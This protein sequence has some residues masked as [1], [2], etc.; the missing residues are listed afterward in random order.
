MPTP[1]KGLGK[2]ERFALSSLAALEQ[3]VVTANDV[4]RVAGLGRPGA[5]Q[6]LSR[7]AR[8]GWLIR[9]RRGAYSLVA[10]S[11]RSG[12]TSSE[13]PMA[14]AMTLF[15]PCYISGWTTAQHWG[16]TE[17]IYNSI[18]VCSAAPQRAAEQVAGGIMFRVRRVPARAI[19]GTTRIWSG[20]TAVEVAN[21]HRTLID[22][23][24]TP[25]LGGGGRQML[26]IAQAYWQ[27]GDA[28]PDTLLEYAERL[29]RGVIF[30][31][32]GLTAEL[33]GDVPSAWF[34]RCRNGLTAGVSSLDPSAPPRGR[35][36]S[37][38]RLR[39]NL[40]IPGLE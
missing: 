25:E 11:S 32:L 12:G 15:A 29:G 31:R 27:R 3:P 38:W 10:L 13:D 14:L 1:F 16:L 9:L 36:I 17:Q 33:F 26:D 8:K 21:V 39:V 5:N 20:A 22:V 4:V 19:F 23:L 24:D 35:I 40:P 2:T 30:K 37:R 7:L 34:T 28:A 18:V 6:L